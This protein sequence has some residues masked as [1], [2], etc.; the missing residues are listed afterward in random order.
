MTAE[1]WFLS[2]YF[3]GIITFGVALVAL[4]LFEKGRSE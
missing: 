3:A 4:V 2:G 1:L